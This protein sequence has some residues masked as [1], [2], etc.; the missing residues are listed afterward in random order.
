MN[1][2]P[3]V[4]L[5]M[6][7]KDEEHII[8]DCLSSIAPYID[9]YDISDT[10]STDRTKEIIKE[11]F[12]EKGIPGKVYDDPWL[13]FGKSR[14]QSLR[15]CKGKADYAW[16]IDADDFVE[17]DFKYPENFG[18]HDG[19]SLNI[20]RGSFNWWRNQIFRVESD[21]EYIGVIHEYADSPTQRA[22]N[23]GNLLIDRIGG[24]Y[25]IHARTMGK[26]TQEFEDDEQAKYLKDAETLV[27]CLKNPEDPNYEPDNARYLFYAGQS[28]FDGGNYGEAY[29][30][31]Q[32]RAEFGGWEEEQWYSVYRMA[33]CL[34]SDEMREKEPDWWQKAQDHLLQAW[35]I[36]P[37]RAEPLLTLARTH[38]LNQNP[39]LA[40]LFARAGVN[41]TFPENDILFL[42]HSVYDWELL[43]ELAAVAHLM[44]DWH[45]GYQ[46]SS[47]LIQEGKFPEEHRQ[48]I[49]NN[50]NSYQQYMLNQQQQQQKQ[51]EEAKQREK[52][53][54]ASR[55][56]HRQDRVA[57]KKKAKRDLDKRN[58]RKSRSR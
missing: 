3:T 49:Q 16:V 54:K 4:T 50:F 52:M 56:K 45:I 34:M 1:K 11:F 23:N 36:R 21:W 55:E 48:R 9:R 39:N 53:E 10:G 57:L 5:C 22:R 33:Q 47:K 58:K 35:N 29:K 38:R 46:A 17:G 24:D 25:R 12:E 43:D 15:N 32:K 18:Q 37:F 51:V 40:Y 30:W 20:F 7:V 6:I 8:R 27:S 28:F 13:G 42:S 44:G 41:I 2:R 31:Y 14:T 26:R 19:Y